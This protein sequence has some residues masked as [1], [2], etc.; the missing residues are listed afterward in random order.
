MT[1]WKDIIEPP[2][3]NYTWYRLNEDGGFVGIFKYDGSK[4]I[5]QKNKKSGEAD[6]SSV[7][8]DAPEEYD[9]LGEIA[10][11]L[12]NLSN[13]AYSGDYAD[14]TNIP[15]QRTFKEFKSNWPT[16]TTLE[17]FCS[18]IINDSDA[19]VGNAYLGGL[20][21]SGL[22]A[23]M[24][25]G[26]VVAEVIGTN[27]N[28]VVKLT[29]TSTDVSPYHWEGCYWQGSFR[30]WKS[31]EL[32]SNKVTSFGANPSDANYPSEKLIK[33][34]LDDKQGRYTIA[35][36]LISNAK[37]GDIT[38]VPAIIVNEN[39]QNAVNLNNIST[40]LSN[41]ETNAIIRIGLNNAG[42]QE[43]F[44]ALGSVVTITGLVRYW[45]MF[46]LGSSVLCTVQVASLG[47]SQYELQVLDANGNSIPYPYDIN[48][49]SIPISDGTNYGFTSNE[50]TADTLS[51]TESI[52]NDK[53][54][55][56]QYLKIDSYHSAYKREYING[57][58][59]E[60][61]V[62][63]I[64]GMQTLT[65]TQKKQV[66]K[67]INAF[68]E[69]DGQRYYK[70]TNGN[71]TNSSVTN[72]KEG[73]IEFY[74][75][76]IIASNLQDNDNKDTGIE[77]E[78]YNSP[79]NIRIAANDSMSMTS[80]RNIIVWAKQYNDE[81]F[82]KLATCSLT[83]NAGGFYINTVRAT[84]EG[85]DVV[86][87]R[88]VYI[89]LDLLGAI[90]GPITVKLELDNTE[91][92]TTPWD[93]CIINV[94]RKINTAKEY[95]NGVWT[96]RGTAIDS[97]AIHF[98]TQSL[99]IDQKRQ[100]KINLDLYRDSVN[101]FKTESTGT[102]SVSKTFSQGGMQ[103]GYFLFDEYKN[104]VLST[105]LPTKAQLLASGTIGDY[106]T[107]ITSDMITDLTAKTFKVSEYCLITEGNDTIYVGDFGSTELNFVEPGVYIGGYSFGGW[108]YSATGIYW[109]TEG[110]PVK[111]PARFIN[112]SVL[113]TNPVTGFLPNEVYDLGELT[114]NV[115]FALAVPT[116]LTIPNPYHW[117]FE[118][119]STPP[120]V[121]W[122][123]N[124]IWTDDIA[125]APTLAADKHYEITVRNGYATLLVF[126]L[127]TV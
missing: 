12:G 114:G 69:E 18:A 108:M 47:N 14:L 49:S 72:P 80:I 119:G 71:T 5:L 36:A 95:I 76:V 89:P 17:A 7:I 110:E 78:N 10:N 44:S 84:I 9:T 83:S 120:T 31:F 27:N 64:T 56:L 26:D 22:P 45:G 117:T 106:G 85:G 55:L 81:T 48:I 101:K 88:Q 65:D 112:P 96:N 97:E 77:V 23:G 37:E 122:P 50:G 121:S 70:N 115:T 34:S 59:R 15:N 63:V 74:D 62:P 92:A 66:R 126:S 58:W 25:Q 28:K 111:V 33:D 91:Y 73:D 21:C 100:T 39:L 38:E 16:G 6:L 116:D 125:P 118:T 51:I 87:G 1:I 60:R 43:L 82:T 93:Y 61:D 107:P 98:T 2:S 102:P 19:N 90:V 57:E 4:W 13:V 8:G 75:D 42:V 24:G 29:L 32:Q 53:Q 46:T 3:S 86:V 41:S 11:A 123:S 105:E 20:S 127:P 104:D 109:Q 99:T 94:V 52:P 124:I 68:E 40:G 54:S 67:N 103:Q 30:G 35:P 79:D 113:S